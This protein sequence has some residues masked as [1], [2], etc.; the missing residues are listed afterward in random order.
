MRIEYDENRRSVVGWCKLPGFSYEMDVISFSNLDGI[1]K[2]SS[3]R[4][5]PANFEAA[6]EIVAC[7]QAAFDKVKE[8]KKENVD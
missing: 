2:V 5:L 1:W 8:L 6:E 7:V 3:S 4:C